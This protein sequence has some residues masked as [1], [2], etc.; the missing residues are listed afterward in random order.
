MEAA[1]RC[2]GEEGQDGEWSGEEEAFISCIRPCQAQARSLVV[3]QTK[4]WKRK[5]CPTCYYE[6][7]VLV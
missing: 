2:V 4:E 6:A 7:N 3:S 1:V 5:M